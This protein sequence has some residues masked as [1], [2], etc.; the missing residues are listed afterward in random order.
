MNK[1]LWKSALRTLTWGYLKNQLKEAWRQRKTVHWSLWWSDSTQKKALAS[2]RKMEES[3]IMKFISKPN[4]K[5][6]DSAPLSSSVVIWGRWTPSI[7]NGQYWVGDLELIYSPLADP[8]NCKGKRRP[9]K[10]YTH[11][12][13]SLQTWS[14]M[15]GAMGM[16]GTGAYTVFKHTNNSGLGEVPAF[17]WSEQV[18]RPIRLEDV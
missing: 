18:T 14:L 12:N 5:V 17:G 7:G 9:P 11:H 3:M 2:P 8:E 10:A 16:C 15:K 6:S 4:K 13:V 1:K